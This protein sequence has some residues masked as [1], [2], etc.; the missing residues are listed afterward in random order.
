MCKRSHRHIEQCEHRVA[1]DRTG[2]EENL[3]F[4]EEERK[5]WKAGIPA[6]RN[7]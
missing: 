6:T 5:E 4:P 7:S 2:T 3:F 1:Q